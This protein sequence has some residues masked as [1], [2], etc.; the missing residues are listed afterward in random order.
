MEG[1]ENKNVLEGWAVWLAE[2]WIGGGKG[3]QYGLL[4]EE[5]H[6]SHHF[7]FISGTEFLLLLIVYFR[8]VHL[9][10]LANLTKSSVLQNIW[11][12]KPG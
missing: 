7:H 12:C 2:N 9:I 11:G 1:K 4:E 6:L 10:L 3:T 5:V 8:E